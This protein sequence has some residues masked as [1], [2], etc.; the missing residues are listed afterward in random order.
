MSD[1]P[2]V[3]Y[4]FGLH[5]HQPVGNFDAVFE[6]H[7]THVYRPLLAALEIGHAF[8]A[9]IHVSGPLLDWLE[10]HGADWL[11]QLGRLAGDGQVELLASGFDEPILAALPRADRLEQVARMRERLR[12]RF[13]VDARGLW[14]T[15]RVWEPDLAGDLAQAGIHYVVV[16]D[17]HFAAAGLERETLHLPWRTEAEG[18]GIT[19]L[20]IDERLRYLVPFRPV[21]DF[22]AYVR[23]L[24][25]RGRRLALLADDGEK[26]GGWPGTREWVYEQG[27]LA[28]YLQTLA[29]LREAGEVE[30]VTC[31]EAAARLPS[32]GLVYLPSASYREMEAWALPAPAARRLAALEA[33]LG[34]RMDGPEGALVRGTHW[35]SFLAKY[36]EAN[37]MHKKMLRLSRRA[38]ER[39]DPE[40]IRHAIGRAQCNDAYWHGVFGGLYLPFL[41]A[42]VWANLAD[43]E[44][45]LRAGEALGAESEDVDFD[46]H[47][48]VSVHGQA[49]AA[50]VSPGRGGGVEELTRFAAR[51]NLADTLSRRREAYHVASVDPPPEAPTGADAGMPSIHDL[52]KRLSLGMLP[53]EDGEPRAIF[54]E[55]LVR[56]EPDATALAAQEAVVVRSWAAERFDVVIE[57]RPGTIEI[58]L[59]APGIEKR[60]QFD[61]SGSVFAAFAWTP[62]APASWFTTELSLAASVALE[63]DAAGEWRYPIETVAKSERGLE[64]TVQGEAVVLGWPAERGRGWVRLP[65]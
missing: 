24:R 46:G 40:E 55:R 38:R 10:T 33:E 53:P 19:V 39:G 61:E 3:L 49:F 14:L 26:F 11:D 4:A 42:A 62:G 51:V 22:A 5:L 1:L 18:L 2:P 16:D 52:E 63:S 32:A 65:S 35:R 21:E 37:R 36:A 64:R 9:T 56:D 54:L 6:D 8:P 50:V 30:L 17:R 23:D 57:R 41:R 28:T 48:E 45:L 25:A 20:P 58:G 7:L 43:A 31:G 60:L 12:R 59:T 15:E 44:R 13:G 27:W 29:D 47:A 34:A